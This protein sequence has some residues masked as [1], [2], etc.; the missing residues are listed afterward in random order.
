MK[1]DFLYVRFGANW[2]AVRRFFLDV[3]WPEGAVCRSC[4]KISDGGVLCPACTARLRDDGAL[5]SWQAEEVEPGLTAYSLRPHQGVARDLVLRLKHQAEACAART[6][7]DLILPLPPDVV[8]PPDTVV[9]WVTMPESRR[10]DRCVDHG[11]L[12]AEET[13]R[14]L[15]LPCR[16][17]LLRRETRE[18]NQASLNREMRQRN[19]QN[20]FSP[21]ETITFPVLLVDDV[22]TT[23]TT[24]RRCAEALRSAGAE[25][26]AV[27]TFTRA[28]G[29]R[30]VW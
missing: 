2:P 6:L 14:R 28:S 5:F 26:V 16:K 23:G 17:L 30:A 9:T 8:F 10:R 18:R 11:R 12:L 24:A 3:V 4:G 19:L 27:L 22:L 7:A 29:S 20:A 15:G 1:T 13:A 25:H 21:A